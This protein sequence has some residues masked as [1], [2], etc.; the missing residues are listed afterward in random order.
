MKLGLEGCQGQT[1]CSKQPSYSPGLC[2]TGTTF[3]Y[4][5][6]YGWSA[7][8][9]VMSGDD[10]DK[11]RLHSLQKVYCLCLV[12]R[13]RLRVAHLGLIPTLAEFF[14]F[15]RSCPSSDFT[16]C[17]PVATHPEAWRYRVSIGT[18]W[19]SV[20]ILWLGEIQSFICNFSKCGST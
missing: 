20:N 10:S 15:A 18:G 11:E 1:T 9:K 12:V 6:L 19:S 13:R 17:M 4:R 2:G 5:R 3:I 8:C 16:I 14:F 7:A